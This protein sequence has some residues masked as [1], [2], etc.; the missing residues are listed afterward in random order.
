[1]TVFGIHSDRAA[2][3]IFGLEFNKIKHGEL[4][5]EGMSE[6]QGCFHLTII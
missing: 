3:K 1:M 5:K 4:T 6:A 2:N